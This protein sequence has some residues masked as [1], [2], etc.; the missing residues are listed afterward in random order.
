MKP[1]LFVRPLSETERTAL[2]QGLRSR[3]AFTLRRCQILLAS[4]K[5]QRP[6]QIAT[7][8]G[9]SVQTVRNTIRAFH[10]DN[11]DCLQAQSSRPKTVQPL[12]DRA[13]QEQLR[14]LLHQSPRIF[15]KCHS[16]WSLELLAQVCWEQDIVPKRVSGVTIHH[17]LKMMG[18]DWRRAKAWIVSPDLQYD[19]KK[20]QRNRLI[21]LSLHHPDWARLISGRGMV[22][23]VATAST[24]QLDRRCSLAVSH[25]SS[26]Q[27]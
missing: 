5:Y 19:L 10:G 3:D 11:L 6:K 9:C 20:H 2:E 1:P 4:A 12:F 25:P 13:K 15:N 27:E 7:Q 16:T 21:E 26:R 18:I 14:A 17:T 22:E 23:S 24:A 8:L